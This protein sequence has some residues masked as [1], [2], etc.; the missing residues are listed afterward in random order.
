MKKNLSDYIVAL[1]VIGCSLFLLVAMT[2]ALSGRHASKS[3]RTVE[4]DYPDVTGIKLHSE[5]RYAG[6]SAGTVTAIRLLTFAEREAAESAE[7]KR[8]AVRVTVTLF[9]EVPPLPSDVRASLSAE[10]MLSE[11]FVALSAGSPSVPKLANGSILQ[12]HSGGGLDGLFDAIGPL[13][14]GLPR[15][16][17][18]AEDLLHNLSPLL[19][20][21][22]EAVDSVKGGVNEI[23]PR[24]T[25]LLDGLKTTS[26]SA[27]VAIKR[28][29]KLIE[30]VDGPVKADLIELKASLVKIQGTLNSANQLI[31]HTDKNLDARLQELAVV[32]QNLKVVTTQ[33]KALTQAIGERPNRLIFSGKPQKLTPEEEILRANKPV[34]AVK[35]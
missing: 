35:P 20:K 23:V 11:K 12:G 7:Q 27:D 1:T 21:T 8:N 13:T 26:E 15:L 34:P 22:G 4:I 2:Y 10:T 6:A 19:A 29:D 25:K 17:A 32:F 24:T 18:T 31:G 16:L 33:A 28:L 30:G 14:E 5:V 3:D 9:K